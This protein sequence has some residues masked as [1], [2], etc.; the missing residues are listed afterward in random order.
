MHVP[1]AAAAAGT[2]LAGKWLFDY[3]RDNFQ[4]DAPQ[5]FGRFLSSRNMLNAQVGQYR[6]DIHGLTELVAGRMDVV[7]MV[8]TLILCVCAALSDAGRIGMHGAAPPQWLCGLYSGNIFM[9]IMFCGTALWLA[10]HGSLRAQCAATSLLTRKVRLPIP[11][12]AMLDGARVFSS[13]FEQQKL[14]DIFR[15]PFMRHPQAAPDLPPASDGESDGEEGG[16]S[17]KEE[18]KKGKKAKDGKKSKGASSSDPRTEFNSTARDTVPSW[19]RDEQ[20]VDK[21]GGLP[22]QAERDD[23]EPH[24]APDHF[25]MLLN[26]NEEWWQYDVYARILMLYGMCTFLYAISYYAIGTTTAELRGFWISWSLPMLFLGAQALIMRLDIVRSGGNHVLPNA[27]IIGHFAPYLSIIGTTLEYR[28]IYS[29]MQV[30]VTWIIVFLAYLSHLIMM[31]RFLD[32]AWPDWNR[33]TDMP[34]EPGK[35]WWPSAWKVPSA[36]QKSLWLLAPPKKLEPGQHD[37]IH[38]AQGLQQTGGGVACRRRNTSDK[39]NKKGGKPGKGEGLSSDMGGVAPDVSAEKDGAYTGKSPFKAFMNLRA[40]DLPWQVT[41]VAICT[42]IFV[43][44]YMM[45]CLFVEAMIGIGNITKPP[46]EPPWIRDTKMVPVWKK[47]VWH[48]SNK[49]MPSNYKLESSTIAKYDDDSVG[50]YNPRDIVSPGMGP[51]SLSGESDSHSGGA[52]HSAGS[53]RRLDS[54]EGQLLAKLL[55]ASDSLDWLKDT[56]DEHARAEQGVPALYDLSPAPANYGQ[57]LGFMAPSVVANVKPVSWPALFEPHHLVCK[58]K[59]AVA[60]TPRGFGAYIH[61]LA[62]VAKAEAQPFAIDGLGGFGSL[63]GAAWHKLGLSLVTKSGHILECPGAEPAESKWSCLTSKVAKL[64]IMQ[65]ARLVAA[66]L[67]EPQSSAAGGRTAALVFE[68]LPHMVSLFTE[69]PETATWSPAGD[70]HMPLEAAGHVSL[71]FAGEELL[72]IIAQ[73]GAVHRHHLSEGS[74]AW[75][76]APQATSLTRE[77]HSACLPEPQAGKLLRLALRRVAPAAESWMPELTSE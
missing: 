11:S 19:I 49:E 31:L 13:A 52:M 75:H 58:G 62:G 63:A 2:G 9:T 34:E 10:M 30:Y 50:G 67:S 24:D 12:M 25:K 21:G 51:S 8:M 17:G 38:E 26:A 29:P 53:H 54:M 15:V 68:H 61:D 60:L 4:Y 6:Q 40:Q 5:R 7:Q 77:Y 41:R 43:Y 72:S 1:A 66:A 64:P 73:T 56:L 48:M 74:T 70:L 42:A 18:G 76:P 39:T 69:R 32:L 35:P 36:F 28:F 27:E 3:N 46:G 33:T 37:L 45:I 65:D 57:D 44:I 16:K 59:S 14:G 71:A 22:G 20:V 47:D 55:K 23:I